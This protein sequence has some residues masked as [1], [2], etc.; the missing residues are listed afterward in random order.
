MAAPR[1]AKARQ[2][3]VILDTTPRGV[4]ASA[5]PMTHRLLSVAA[6]AIALSAWAGQAHAEIVFLTSGRSLSVKSHRIDGD[7]IILSL[8]TGGEVMCDGTLVDKILPDEVPHPDPVALVAGNGR[9][10]GSG[11]LRRASRVDSG[12]RDYFRGVGSTRRRSPTGASGHSGRVQLPGP[13]P[14]A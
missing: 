13:R 12:R 10:T 3:V 9:G 2:T 6:V 1:G 5:L 11:T 14:L 4:V 8:R 7:W